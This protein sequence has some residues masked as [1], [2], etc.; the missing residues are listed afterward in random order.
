MSPGKITSDD[1]ENGQFKTLSKPG[2]GVRM[3]YLP[4]DMNDFTYYTCG[5]ATTVYRTRNG[6]SRPEADVV[7][8]LLEIGVAKA[9]NYIE[10]MVPP[11][12]TENKNLRWSVD[13]DCLAVYWKG[14][15]SLGVKDLRIDLIRK[16][17]GFP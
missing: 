14:L 1:I 9:G 17:N 3:I 5:N 8:F 12:L 6:G 7:D 16:F 10:G 13:A 2:D 11:T 4:K 15:S